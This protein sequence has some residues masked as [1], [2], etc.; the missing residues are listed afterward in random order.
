MIKNKDK[1]QIYVNLFYF[2]GANLSFQKDL[3]KK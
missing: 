3:S 1:K 2:C